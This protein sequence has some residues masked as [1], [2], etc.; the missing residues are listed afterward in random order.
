MLGPMTP[1]A[2]TTDGAR[3]QSRPSPCPSVSA[4]FL[5]NDEVLFLSASLQPRQVYFAPVSES[6]YYGWL[7]CLAVCCSTESSLVAAVLVLFIEN[8][9]YGA[10]DLLNVQMR[11]L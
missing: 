3:E 6:G 8:G 11:C 5:K 10:A 1:T 2:A 9:F 4:R 7:F